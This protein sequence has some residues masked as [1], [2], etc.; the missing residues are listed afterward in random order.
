MGFGE[1]EDALRLTTDEIASQQ[2]AEI[3]YGINYELTISV[4]PN[5]SSGN[6]NIYA[7]KVNSAASLQLQITNLLGEVVYSEYVE[8]AN[9]IVSKSIELV[10]DLS[11]GTYFLNLLVDGKAYSASFI[12]NR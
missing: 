10:N 1:I 6:I 11:N 7:D 4:S 8:N 9:G 3:S 5:P 2:E 12:L